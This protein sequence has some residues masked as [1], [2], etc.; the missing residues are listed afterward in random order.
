MPV[1]D[2]APTV[3]AVGA[4]LRSRTKDNAGNE[5]GTFTDQTRPTG[6]EVGELI[7][8]ATNDVAAEVGADIVSARRPYAASVAALGTALQVELTYFPEQVALGRSPYAE[9]KKLYDER[10][11]R[12][13]TMVEGGVDEDPTMSGGTPLDPAY[14]FTHPI[15]PMDWSRAL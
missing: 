13:K 7:G 15:N 1:E 9:L 12:L 10:L 8:T 11:K 14:E 6:E 2:W 3:A 4:I 5:L